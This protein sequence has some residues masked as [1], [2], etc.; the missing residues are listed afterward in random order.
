MNK[1]SLPWTEPLNKFV[2]LLCPKGI[3]VMDG[4]L[5]H[6]LIFVAVNQTT[7]R[8]LILYNVNLTHR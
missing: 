4:A 8:K 6:E 3:A 5:V 2:G 7:I 1:H